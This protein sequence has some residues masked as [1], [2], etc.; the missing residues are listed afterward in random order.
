MADDT[1]TTDQQDAPPPAT[2]DAAPPAELGDAGKK[3]L[4]RMKAERDEARKQAKANADAAK[5]LS[6]IEEQSKSET[7]KA[8]EAVRK[9]T[10]KLVRA[11][12]M[13]DRVLDRIEVA[14]ADRFASTEDARLRLTPRADDF[15][16]DGQ[17]DTDAIAKALDE[18]LAANPHLAKKTGVP[19]PDPSQGKSGGRADSTPGLGRLRDAYA[20]SS[21]TP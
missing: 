6:E 14:A 2:E 4:D 7:E 9:E 13:R 18:V 19:R 1:G 11:E 10:E 21:K 3:A 5:R 17:I 16:N 12:V 15:V 8:I 20:N